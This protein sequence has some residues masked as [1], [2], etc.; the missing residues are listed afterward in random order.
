M[1]LWTYQHAITLL[2]AL[3]IMILIAV[4]L[5][6]TIGKRDDK[7]RRIPLQILAVVLLVLEVGKQIV[8]FTRGYDLYHIPLHFCSLFL[9]TMPLAAFYNGKY[10]QQVRAINAAFCTAMTALLLI[11]P[12]LIY[13]LYKEEL[14]IPVEIA[15]I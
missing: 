8:S 11:Y 6:R 14:Q 9:V 4:L 12:A 2:P 10:V 1:E 7:I 3:G 15:K 13:P 5:R